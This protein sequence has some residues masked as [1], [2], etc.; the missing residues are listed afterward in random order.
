MRLALV[1]LGASLGI[2]CQVDAGT[3]S[4]AAPCQP[5]TDVFISDVRLG[6]FD[7][8]QCAQSG[9]HASD[10]SGHGYFRL[11]PFGTAPTLGTPLGS[12]PDPWRA[13]YENAIQLVRCDDALQSRLLTVP[14]AKADPH[15]VDPADRV[16][17]HVMAEGIF[18]K[19]VR[20]F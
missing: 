15:P 8:N 13:N 19:W 3:V 11:Q 4:D 2:G 17:D 10:D 6:Y 7:S 12:W 14:E 18:Q 20:G 9:C 16:Q 5:S 1:V